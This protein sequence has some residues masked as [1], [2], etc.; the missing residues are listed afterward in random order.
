M[1][2]TTTYAICI[3]TIP[4]SELHSI[5]NPSSSLPESPNNSSFDSLFLCWRA[6]ASARWSAL[7]TW[8][9]SNCCAGNRFSFRFR[10]SAILLRMPGAHMRR[11]SDCLRCVIYSPSGLT[12]SPRAAPAVCTRGVGPY[13]AAPPSPSPARRPAPP[14]DRATRGGP[15]RSGAGAA[16]RPQWQDSRPS[17]AAGRCQGG[18]RLT[19][20]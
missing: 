17:V 19:Y 12:P 13:C 8:I 15:P 14:Q 6:L 11:A 4:N 18:V 1:F 2:R 3:Y 10:C 16:G 20:R 9:W 7:V 5:K